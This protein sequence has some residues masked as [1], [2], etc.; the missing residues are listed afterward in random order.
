L[1]VPNLDVGTLDGTQT[2]DDAAEGSRTVW[3]DSA[4]ALTGTVEDDELRL[5]GDGEGLGAGTVVLRALAG[6]TCPVE[7]DPPDPTCAPRPV[8]GAAVELWGAA[9]ERVA[10]AT[11][12]ALGVAVFEVDAGRYRVQPLPVEGVTAP[13]PTT[14]QVGAD[15]T[16][17]TL[18]YDTGIR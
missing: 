13:D 1:A 11:T 18:D 15:V 3:S 4:I 17:L 6:P 16:S 8:A 7:S 5:V 2:D 12:D 14:V 10:A 9:D